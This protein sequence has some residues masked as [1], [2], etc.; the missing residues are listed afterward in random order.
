M[1][2]STAKNTYHKVANT[3]TTINT[4]ADTFTNYKKLK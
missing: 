3:D 2:P 1:N 4:S